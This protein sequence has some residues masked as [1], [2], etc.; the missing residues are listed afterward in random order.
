MDIAKKAYEIY[1]KSGQ[2]AVCDF[3]TSVGI[4]ERTPCEPCET[5]TPTHEGDC[6]VCG[7][8]KEG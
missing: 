3:A 6:L 5:D 1:Q 4:T 7:T 2:D 8:V